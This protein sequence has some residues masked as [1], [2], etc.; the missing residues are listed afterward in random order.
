[1]TV[2]ADKFTAL[3]LVGNNI[4]D[5]DLRGSAGSGGNR[6]NRHTLVFGNVSALQAFNVGMLGIVDDNSD[7]LGGIDGGAAANSDNLVGANRLE[8]FHAALNNINGRIGLNFVIHLI[9]QAVSV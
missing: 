5:G 8:H 1:M 3:F 4:V 2:G 7:A 6:D 9:G